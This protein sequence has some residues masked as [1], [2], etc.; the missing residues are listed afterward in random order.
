[1]NRWQQIIDAHPRAKLACDRVRAVVNGEVPDRIP[2]CDSFWPEFAVRYRRDRDL[3]PDVS[4]AEHFDFDYVSTSTVTH[5]PWPR[6][7]GVV[8]REPGGYLLRRSEYGLVTREIEGAMGVPQHVGRK[9]EE[10]HDLDRYAF[11]DPG[12]SERS[13]AIEKSLP[14]ICTRFCPVFKL[15]GPFSRS[16]QLRGLSQFLLDIAAD[17]VFA[18]EMVDRMTDHM[19]ACGI[20]AIERLD[21]PRILWH[22]A[23]D[24][25]ATNAP[26]IS[27]KA[28][29]AIF[30][31]N[32][33]K[34]VDALHEQ[35]FKVSYE[36]EG[37]VRPMLEFL[38]ASGVDCLAHMEPRAGLYIGEIRQRFGDRFTFMGQICNALVLPSN[39]R[40]AVAREVLRVLSAATDGHYM[41]LSAHSIAPDVSSDTYDY[42]WGLMDRYG[43]YPM[44][45]SGLKVEARDDRSSSARR[46]RYR[47]GQS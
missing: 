24:F 33:K 29:E 47:R 46:G 14:G 39:D 23:D 11:E 41:T 10:K 42:F 5:G 6:E 44:D 8:G 38:D 19:I 32:L 26:L 34:M 27:P 12:D 7:A 43:R 37:N 16:W 45:L 3:S 17:P 25:A 36:S 20:A 21:P 2:F 4:L 30:L 18:R 22:I 35:G 31:P 9:I 13:A 40:V 28:Y 1:M 15:G